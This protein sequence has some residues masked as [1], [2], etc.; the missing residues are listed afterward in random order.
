[1]KPIL[2]ILFLSTP[3]FAQQQNF[4]LDPLEFSDCLPRWD[5]NIKKVNPRQ[6][7]EIRHQLLQLLK[8]EKAKPERAKLLHR[9]ALNYF[10]Q[11]QA[12]P[13][14]KYL[15]QAIKVLK[16]MIPAHPR[17][18][19]SEE[20]YLLLAEVLWAAH[21]DKEALKVLKM[22]IRKF[23]TSPDIPR[24]Y[25]FFGEFFFKEKQYDRASKMYQKADSFGPSDYSYCLSHRIAYCHYKLGNTQLAI[26]WLNK[27]N[28]LLVR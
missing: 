23:P 25:I 16:K 6:L 15:D 11:Y 10:Q 8:Y 2:L 9:L 20:I 21:S 13:D 18:E 7:P 3:A 5:R 1:M 14:E 26:E 12:K 22:F 4:Q 19:K 28:E 24:A 17:Y 27:A